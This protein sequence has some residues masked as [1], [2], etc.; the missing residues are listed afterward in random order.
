MATP[1]SSAEHCDETI[2]FFNAEQVTTGLW[3]TAD[4]EPEISLGEACTAPQG[5]DAP[6]IFS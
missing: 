5:R 1:T 3:N 6:M 4:R 2:L